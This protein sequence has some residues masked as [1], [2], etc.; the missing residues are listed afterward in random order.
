MT[1][2]GG[3]PVAEE[4][5]ASPVTILDGLGRVVRVVTA[6]EFRRIHGVPEGP[7]PDMWRRRRARA[8]PSGNAEDAIEHALV[9]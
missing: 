4:E 3:R 1:S 5:S 8:K 2:P 6:E 9:G 7:K